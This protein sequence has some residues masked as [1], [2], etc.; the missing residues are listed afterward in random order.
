MSN[1]NYR[2]NIGTVKGAA[3]W[4]EPKEQ[5]KQGYFSVT[6]AR[7]S[8]DQTGEWVESKI[9]L[10]P[11]ELASMAIILQQLQRVV[12][13]PVPFEIQRQDNGYAQPATQPAAAPAT[14]AT[15]SALVGDDIPF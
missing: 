13:Q 8:K 11:N 9:N 5:G 14:V 1:K 7:A 2:V 15:T 12:F 3:F 6:L 10:F 4:N